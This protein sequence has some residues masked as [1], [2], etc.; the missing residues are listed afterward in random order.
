MIVTLLILV[1]A[2]SPPVVL[3]DVRDVVGIA[4]RCP[5]RHTTDV[6]VCGRRNADR[7]R[8]PFATAP[9]AGGGTA[10]NAAAERGALLHHNTPVQDLGPFLV[11]G[12]HAGVTA[13][14]GLDGKPGS[15]KPRVTGMRPLAP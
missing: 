9:A 5:D 7:F 13:G 4:N 14:V 11:G 12:G 6:T 3:R 15:G 10:D 1:E 2:A 8:V